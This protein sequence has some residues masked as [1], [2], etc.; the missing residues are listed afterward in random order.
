MHSKEVYEKTAMSALPDLCVFNHVMYDFY[1][2]ET[3]R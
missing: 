3:G 2:A 1:V